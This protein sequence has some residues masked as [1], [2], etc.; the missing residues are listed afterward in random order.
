MHFELLDENTFRLLKKNYVDPQLLLDFHQDFWG[1]ICKLLD[2]T[3][4]EK[5]FENG[6]EDTLYQWWNLLFLQSSLEA[7]VDLQCFLLI[8]NMRFLLVLSVDIVE[9]RL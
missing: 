8:P 6:S 4:F 5:S 3:A 1:R 7:L 2:L 9:S